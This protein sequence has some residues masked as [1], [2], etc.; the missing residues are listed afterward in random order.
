MYKIR[1]RADSYQDA[2]SNA[3]Q[4]SQPFNASSNEL[5][6]NNPTTIKSQSAETSFKNEPL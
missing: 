2:R 1:I 4:S 5:D 6:A 3:I